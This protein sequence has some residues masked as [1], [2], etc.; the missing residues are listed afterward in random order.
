MWQA[1]YARAARTP[2]ADLESA[3]DALA[4]RDTESI[5]CAY[6]ELG[7]ARPYRSR[8]QALESIRRRVLDRHDTYQRVTLGY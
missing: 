5:R 6:A 1:L 3:L 8:G 4:G 2:R 7:F